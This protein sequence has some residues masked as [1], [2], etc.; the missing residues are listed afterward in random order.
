MKSQKLKTGQKITLAGFGVGKR[1]Q[2]VLSGRAVDTNRKSVAVGLMVYTIV[3]VMTHD[4]KV[5]ST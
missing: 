5:E 3:G 2:L 1:G 4:G